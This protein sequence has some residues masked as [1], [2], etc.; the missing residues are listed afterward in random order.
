MSTDTTLEFEMSDW[1]AYRF[2]RTRM[3]FAVGLAAFGFALVMAPILLDSDSLATAYAFLYGTAF[4]LFG[5][6]YTFAYAN[7]GRARRVTDWLFQSVGEDDYPWAAHDV[8]V[9]YRDE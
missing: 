2:H 6:L 1:Q 5:A 7:D 9:T 4:A 3:W 8:E